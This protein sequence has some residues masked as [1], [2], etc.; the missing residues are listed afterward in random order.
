MSFLPFSSSE[1]ARKW[2]MLVMHEPMKTSS[3][4]VS[5]TADSRRASSGSLGAHRMGSFTSARS[6]SMTW[7]YSA[8]ASASSRFGAA[9]QASMASMRRC[10]VRAS[11]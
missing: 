1:A 11:A 10:R 6:I 8:S 7:A 3:I 4:G 9:S 2:P 5:C